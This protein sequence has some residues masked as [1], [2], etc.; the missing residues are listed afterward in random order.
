MFGVG[1]THP[2]R[3]CSGFL[4]LAEQPLYRCFGDLDPEGFGE[5]ASGGS[6]AMLAPVARG[7]L[8]VFGRIGGPTSSIQEA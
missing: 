8:E 3:S 6:I 7:G 4:G 2:L 1:V 5:P